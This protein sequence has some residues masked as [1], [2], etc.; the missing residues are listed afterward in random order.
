[1]KKTN[2]HLVMAV[3]QSKLGKLNFLM[4]NVYQ[5]NMFVMLVLLD[6]HYELMM[7][8][9]HLTNVMLNYAANPGKSV[10]KSS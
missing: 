3:A 5:S 7:I 2:L 6:L 8:Q 9:V 4:F 10:M 1:M